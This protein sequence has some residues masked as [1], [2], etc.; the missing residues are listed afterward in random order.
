MS[1]RV[2]TVELL[3]PLWERARKAFGG[4]R[5]PASPSE[6]LALVEVIDA[7][8]DKFKGEGIPWMLHDVDCPCTPGNAVN[9]Q[10]PG[11]CTCG[12]TR[13]YHARKN[14]FRVIEQYSVKV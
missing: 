3:K 9:A 4:K 13:L 10:G 2:P 14:L 5:R 8:E 11:R 7:Y 12:L 1:D 6:V